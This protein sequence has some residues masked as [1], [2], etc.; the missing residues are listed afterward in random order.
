MGDFNDAIELKPCPF[1][2]GTAESDSQRGY[3]NMTTGNLE[4]AAAIYCTSCEAD[5][6]WCY[7]D[8]PEIACED[9]MS[10]LIEKWNTRAVPATDKTVAEGIARIIYE[11][12]PHY[13][14]GEC[15]DGH[16]VSPGGNLS[17]EQARDRDAEFGD[18]ALFVK[19]TKEPLELADAILSA[20]LVTDEAA[21]RADE[22][23]KCAA[24]DWNKTNETP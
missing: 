1:C 9:V 6:T 19:L 7:R 22:R 13:E 24:I 23:E 21:I 18:D 12:N 15:A 14:S 5:M 16:Q 3:R 2:K 20:G 4:Y 11:S 8:T 17:W 10:L